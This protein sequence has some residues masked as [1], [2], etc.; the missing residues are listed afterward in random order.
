[1]PVVIGNILSLVASVWMMAAGPI[2]E[3][4][5]TLWHQT[6]YVAVFL[7]ADVILGGISGAVASAITIVRNAMYETGR[8]RTWMTA[9]FVAAHYALSYAIGRTA[10]PLWLLPPTASSILVVS[11]LVGSDRPFKLMIIV[12]LLL[13]LVYD[14]SIRAYTGAAFDVLC[15]ATN[16]IGLARIMLGTGNVAGTTGGGDAP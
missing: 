6:G 13:W 12:E 2:R 1:M 4:G 8:Y 15:I 5:R 9:P 11:L 10:S 14:V 16:I 3:K 7:V